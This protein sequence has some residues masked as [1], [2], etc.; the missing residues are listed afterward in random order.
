MDLFKNNSKSL[1]PYPK[2]NTQNMDSEYDERWPEFKPWT[3]L[4]TFHFTITPSEMTLN[5]SFPRGYA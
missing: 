3:K 1:G 2:K 5:L 4:S